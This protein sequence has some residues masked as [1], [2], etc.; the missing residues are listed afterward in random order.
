MPVRSL[1]DTWNLIVK[2]HYR[3]LGLPHNHGSSGCVY[4]CTIAGDD[5]NTSHVALKVASF[6]QQ[7][8]HGRVKIA[9]VHVLHESNN[10]HKDGVINA[11]REAH[12]LAIMKS[13]DSTVRLVKCDLAPDGI[14]AEAGCL[15]IVMDWLPGIH[16]SESQCVREP[17]DSDPGPKVVWQAQFAEDM[18][19]T[20]LR[21]A[22][23][24]AELHAAGIAHHD[25]K[26]GNISITA[27]KVTLIDL[28]AASMGG[29][30]GDMPSIADIWPSGQP[31]K[32]GAHC[33]R[34]PEG[35][36]RRV[37]P[38]R[39]TAA[40]SRTDAPFRGSSRATNLLSAATAPSASGSVRN[41]VELNQTETED[42]HRGIVSND[43]R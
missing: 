39:T 38:K 7:S 6:Q 33:T 16:H 25:L 18:L 29:D 34:F 21:I 23:A 10:V 27:T 32:C 30:T 13:A 12:V 9:A 41:T 11:L 5:E 20:S 28:G 37:F 42:L 24:V 22:G 19:S 31:D 3:E 14:L 40:S 4:K 15:G 1:G 8:S 2:N 35:Y 36:Y 17:T 26:C 43:Y